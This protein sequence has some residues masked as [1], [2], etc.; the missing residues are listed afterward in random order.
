MPID[1]S[2]PISPSGRDRVRKRGGRGGLVMSVEFLPLD[3]DIGI[4]NQRIWIEQAFIFRKKIVENGEF[5]AQAQGAAILYFEE[6]KGMF[7]H[8]SKGSYVITTFLRKNH[9]SAI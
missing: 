2:G 4:L 6:Q 3:K 7:T 1:Q 5:S 8:N 9:F